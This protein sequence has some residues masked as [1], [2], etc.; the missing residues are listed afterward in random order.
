[1]PFIWRTRQVLV[2]NDGLNLVHHHKVSIRI[3]L[4][5]GEIAPIR[6]SS[7]CMARCPLHVVE[8]LNPCRL[9]NSPFFY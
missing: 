5:F 2:N 9:S 6:V 4:E 3:I 8:H 7:N 1:M